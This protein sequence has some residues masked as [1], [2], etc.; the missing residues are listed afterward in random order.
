MNINN[1]IWKPG[2]GY[3]A[4]SLQ[5]MK[6]HLPCPPEPMGEAWFMAEERY[7]FKYLYND[8]DSISVNDLQQALEEI[9]SGTSSF[10]HLS[11]WTEWFNYLLPRLIPRSHES[12]VDYLL[13]YLVT[14]YL[15][16]YPDDDFDEPYLG[17]REDSIRTLGSAMMDGW[18]WR[19]NRIVVG[20]IL[21]ES[22]NNPNKVWCWWDASGDF[23][24]SL[25]FCIKYLKENELHAWFNS[26]FDISCPHWRAQLI[27]WLIGY[28]N[29]LEKKITQLSMLPG[30]AY[31][32]ID[33]A[34]SHCITGSYSNTRSTTELMPFISDAKLA[35]TSSIIRKR[36]TPKVI[37]SWLQS[38][39]R[40]RYL[41]DE[42]AT[43]P[44]TLK[45]CYTVH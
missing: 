3:C 24:A 41:L 43:L 42:L 8:I 11:E 26:L 40:H 5:R 1:F 31:P 25:F 10:G 28:K 20:R 33:W 34:W 38:M 44:S 22:N 16:Q 19:S 39:S 2:N 27:V 9:A 14:A 35:I 45:E 36:V 29:L 23:S 30:N 17:F 4:E 37:D 15:T 13:E 7:L 18:C 12:F 32:A 21:H 6:D